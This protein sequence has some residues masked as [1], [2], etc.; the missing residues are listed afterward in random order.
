[1]CCRRVAALAGTETLV[2]SIAAGTT[3]ATLA[4]HFGADTAIVRAMPNTPAAIG[5]GISALYANSSVT[6]E[7]RDA[8]AGLLGRSAKRSGSRTKRK[9]MR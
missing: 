9:W 5:R 3:V 1:M 4:R 2:I 8:C 6:P 7:Q